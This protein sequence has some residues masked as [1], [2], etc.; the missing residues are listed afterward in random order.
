MADRKPFLEALHDRVFLFDGGIGTELYGRGVF[1]NRCFDELSLSAPELVRQVHTDYV[2]VGADVIETNTYGANRV[3]LSKYGFGEHT[4][5]I[6]LAAARLA[7]EAAGGNVYV[8]GAIGPLGIRI[9]P[10]GPTSVAEAEEFFR[11]Q[12]E[13][14]AKGG[15]DLFVLETFSDLNEIHA[16]MRAV[17]AVSP[18]PVVASMTIEEDGNSLEGTAPEVF[19][20]RLAEWGADVVGINCGVGPAAMLAAV[21]RI[22]ETTDRRI[23][24][25][26]NAGR[27]RNIDGRSLYLCSPDYFASYARRFI[28]AGAQIVGGCCGTTPDH[29]RAI[30]R[31]IRALRPAEH[32]VVHPP[33]EPAAPAVSVRRAEKSALA[34]ALAGGKFVACA[35][36]PPPAGSDAAAILEGARALRRQGL[37]AVV[38]PERPSASARMTPQAFAQL[39]RSE[40]GLET[41]VE[42]GCRDRNLTGMQA[43]L[44]GAWV[45][46]L[47]NLLVVTGDPFTTD[48]FDPGEGVFD[49][50]S[51]GLAN[52]VRRLNQGIDIG[53]NPIGPPTAFHVGVRLDPCAADRERE[54]RR[55]EWKL[56][57]GVDYAVTQPLFDVAALERFVA[58][59]PV[60]I[61]IVASI[62]PLESLQD[63]EFLINELRVVIPEAY[64]D[65]MRRAEEEGRGPAEGL[66][67]AREVLGRLKGLAQGALVSAPRRPCEAALDVFDGFPR[68]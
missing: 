52:M 39:L 66:A 10:W 18:L 26:P 68:G 16:A 3:K 49:V 61:P 44:L 56:E 8:A 37:D 50:D 60:P 13:A 7:R 22:A 25:M 32:T 35:E 46:G 41:V 58:D 21:E 6:N 24:V 38:I 19:A 51:I 17:R 62:V 1:V 42:Y 12:A 48:L 23:C 15:V 53:G 27:P 20:A 55:L 45:L 33:L 47:R 34:A 57:A 40:A 2:D 64:Q 59:V 31:A 14:L 63:A 29:I 5:A 4:L 30:R 36:V 28:K 11:E 67:I 9:E 65:R 43:D 54:I